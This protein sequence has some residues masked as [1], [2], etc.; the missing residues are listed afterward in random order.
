MPKNNKNPNETNKAIYA[1]GGILWHDTPFKSDIAIINRARYGD[2]WCLPK[3]KQRDGETLEQ[4]A[5][6]EVKE[7]TGCEVRIH[8]FANTQK[9]KVKESEK[10]VFYWNMVLEGECNF[11]TSEEVK[12][13]VWLPV[14][15]AIK[16]LTHQD[17]KKILEKYV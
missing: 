10:Q 7:E 3:G 13:M 9:Y 4:T 11:R 8:S 15:E 14:E 6:R 1:G 16:L 5:I 2:E 12:Q 17:Q